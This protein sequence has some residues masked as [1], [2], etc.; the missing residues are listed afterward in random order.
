MHTNNTIPDQIDDVTVIQ[1][2]NTMV[3]PTLMKFDIPL[4]IIQLVLIKFGGNECKI[5]TNLKQIRA[6]KFR[7]LEAYSI[8]KHS[9]TK[10]LFHFQNHIATDNVN[11]V[12]KV[13]NVDQLHLNFK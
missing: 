12:Y 10:E 1:N 11:D 9:S 2:A 13:L 6:V 5:F 7:A 8:E 3:A 4:E